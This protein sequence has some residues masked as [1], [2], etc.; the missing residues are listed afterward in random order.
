MKEE[1]PKSVKLRELN[2][3][4]TEDDIRVAMSRFGTVVRVKIPED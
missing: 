1:D 3:S 4:I 2:A